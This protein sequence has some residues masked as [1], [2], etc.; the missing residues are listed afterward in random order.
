MGKRT[1]RV[2]VPSHRP[3]DLLR[4]A[5]RILEKS[6]TDGVGC[7]IAPADLANIQSLTDSAVIARNHSI[8]L[9]EESEG[10]M[11]VARSAM[12]IEKGQT[13]STPNTINYLIAKI[14]DVLMVTYRGREEQL[15][16]Y[17]FN[18]VVNAYVPKSK[19]NKSIT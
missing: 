7:P 11:Q 16:Q 10:E 1:V 13:N 3:G 2:K 12:G 14:R 4:L 17:G 9:R 6:T 19:E 8:E 15:S 18:V 5:Q